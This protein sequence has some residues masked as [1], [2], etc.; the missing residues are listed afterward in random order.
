MDDREQVRVVLEAVVD[1]AGVNDLKGKLAQ[2]LAG[3]E[4]LVLDGSEVQRVD[5]AGLQLLCAFVQTAIGAGLQPRWS[6]ISEPLRE[7]A[8]LTGLEAGMAMDRVSNEV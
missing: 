8:R 4:P 3:P 7:A 1:I 5:T 6:G 2:H